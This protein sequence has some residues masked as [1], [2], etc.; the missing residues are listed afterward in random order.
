[1]IP[2]TEAPPA[3]RSPTLL[4]VDDLAVAFTTEGGDLRALDGVSLEVRRGETVALV[5]ESGCG[6]TATALS[7]LRL[8]PTPPAKVLRGDVRFEGQSLFALDAR[9]MQRVRGGQIGLVFQEPM[10]A[11]NPVYTIGFQVAEA[12]SLHEKISRK[13]VRRRA[14]EALRRVRFPDPERA[15]SAYPHELSGGMRQRALIAI[16]LAAGPKLLIAD[17][18][19]TALDA[20]LQAEILD[21]LRAL[22]D[23]LGLAVLLIAHDLA[24]VSEIASEIVVL[25]AGVVVERGKTR[26]VLDAPQHPYTRALRASV[27]PE[28]AYRVRGQKGRKLA[29]IEGTLP[30]LRAPPPGCR[31]AARCPDVFERCRSETP[32][33]FP[34]EGGEARCFLLDPSRAV[35]HLALIDDRASIP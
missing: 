8:L 6:K 12:I 31:F 35:K 33:M 16:A 11:L 17:E 4:E 13:E 26:A 7:I 25:Y 1:M 30:D 24:L 5:G 10:T 23:E 14:I 15:F 9:G 19:T 21:L 34:T 20:T 32:E 27:P 2:K 29:T 28:R 22:R 18:P 3:D